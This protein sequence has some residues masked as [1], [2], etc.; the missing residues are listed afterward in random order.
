MKIDF[1]YDYASPWSFL[2]SASIRERFAGLDVAYVPTYLRGF[3]TFRDGVPYSSAKLVYLL[4]DFQRLADQLGL[5]VKTPSH[6]PINGVHALRGAIAAQREGVFDAYHRA[7]FAAAWQEDR[8][9][10]A[11]DV[12]KAIAREIGA[13]AVADALGEES[14]KAAL[15]ANT[16]RVLARGA[17]GV[18]AFFVGEELFWGQDRMLEAARFARG[19]TLAGSHAPRSR[20]DAWAIARRWAAA[21][22]RLDVEAVLEHFADEVVFVSPVAKQV[23]G[24]ARVA[25]KDALRTYWIAAVKTITAMRFDVVDVAWSPSE[26]LLVVVYDRTKDGALTH[27]TEHMRFDAHGRVAEGSAFYGA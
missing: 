21:W 4:R 9:L 15:R 27:C 10:S 2:A 13:P 24:N 6:F 25:G 8:N 3:E 11:P 18:P 7:T 1:A 5:D 12:V 14:I 19:E 20:E 17:F 23:T 22:S 26:R 16:D